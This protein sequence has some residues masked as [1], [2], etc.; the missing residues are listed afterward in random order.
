M[1]LKPW[2]WGNKDWRMDVSACWPVSLDNLP[3]PA[4]VGDSYKAKGWRESSVIK[5]TSS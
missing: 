4:S 1:Q 5:S 2:C 3:S